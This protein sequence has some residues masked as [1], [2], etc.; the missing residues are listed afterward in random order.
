MPRMLLIVSRTEPGR[1]A[2]VRHIF[3]NETVDVI[4]DL[5]E[6]PSMAG[7]QP[8]IALMN[9]APHPAA[10]PAAQ[11]GPTRRATRPTSA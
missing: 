9:N 11:P 2:Y 3:A 8:F 6:I 4:M 7:G 10:A 5:P 1:Y